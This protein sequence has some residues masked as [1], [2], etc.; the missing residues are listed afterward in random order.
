MLKEYPIFD[1]FKNQWA[2]VTSGTLES[3]DGCTVGWGVLGLYG[4]R[5]QL[6]SMCILQ[7][8]PVSF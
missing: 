2:L 1:M 8:I 5:I 7:D 6:Q 3:Y 4:I